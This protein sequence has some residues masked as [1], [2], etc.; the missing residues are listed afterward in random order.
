MQGLNILV[1]DDHPVIGV[2]FQTIFHNL[3]LGAS[4]KFASN[5][6][7]A[8]ALLRHQSFDLIFMDIHMPEKNGIESTAEIRRFNDRVKIVGMS[9][10]DE[11]DQISKII[12]AGANGFTVKTIDHKELFQLIRIVMSGNLYLSEKIKTEL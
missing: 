2:G 1:V 7:E 8:I 6:L 4:T 3:N 9:A 12:K 10:Y 11:I 5:G